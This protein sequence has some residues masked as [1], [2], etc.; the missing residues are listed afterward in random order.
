MA[1]ATLLDALRTHLQGV[2][3]PA[4][5]LVAGAYP[6]VAA[7]LPAVTVSFASVSERLRGLARLPAPTQTGALRVDTTLDLA[8]PVVVF[9][10]ETVRLLSTD[11]RTV[12]LVHGPIVRA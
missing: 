10:D 3:S 6:A 1:L 4:P 8:N 5:A 7:E 2:L 12:Q 11:R 9:P